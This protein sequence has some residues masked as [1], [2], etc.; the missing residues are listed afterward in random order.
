[1]WYFR[2]QKKKRRRRGESFCFTLEWTCENE[3]FVHLSKLFVQT[4]LKQWSMAN[5]SFR[6]LRNFCGVVLVFYDPMSSI[7]FYWIQ[8]CNNTWREE[9]NWN[10]KDIYYPNI[11]T[12]FFHHKFF[13]YWYLFAI[14]NFYL[15]HQRWHKI[16]HIS[17]R[18]REI[19]VNIETLNYFSF[20]LCHLCSSRW[21][22]LIAYFGSKSEYDK[23]RNKSIHFSPFFSSNIDLWHQWL[24]HQC[25]LL[26]GAKMN[27]DSE[28]NC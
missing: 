15:P 26:D 7:Q 28:I 21:Q 12:S 17:I 24:L 5:D 3:F 13:A 14:M 8:P 23:Q 25:L 2:W 16:N 11:K 10:L 1:M 9:T 20:I 4:W 27:R 18:L 19:T 6:S 22:I